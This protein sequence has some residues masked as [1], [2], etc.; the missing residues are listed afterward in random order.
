MPA[1]S[2]AVVGCR[3]NSPSMPISISFRKAWKWLFLIFS[4]VKVI[5]DRRLSSGVAFLISVSLVGERFFKRK[6]LKDPLPVIE[7]PKIL[8]DLWPGVKHY[9]KCVFENRGN[10]IQ[11]GRACLKISSSEKKAYFEE[12]LAAFRTIK[13]PKRP[14]VIQEVQDK[15]AQ[16]QPS[17]ADIEDVEAYTL[18]ERWIASFAST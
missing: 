17:D 4:V 5:K 10:E 7:G 3:V 9:T 2:Q 13:D 11:V 8:S 12:L 1:I 14:D 15:I 18:P 6:A 16:I